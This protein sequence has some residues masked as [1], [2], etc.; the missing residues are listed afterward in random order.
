[1]ALHHR[2]E[3]LL[4]HRVQRDQVEHMKRTQRWLHRS[5]NGNPRMLV[6]RDSRHQEAIPVPFDGI[7]IQERGRELQHPQ[8][9]LRWEEESRDRA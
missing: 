1:M 6:K 9:P 7:P 2:S 3:I 8:T 5:H 4:R